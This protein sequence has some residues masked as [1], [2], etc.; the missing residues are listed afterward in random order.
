VQRYGFGSRPGVRNKPAT[1][2]N[3]WEVCMELKAGLHGQYFLAILL[4]NAISRRPYCRAQQYPGIEKFLLKLHC[5]EISQW[6]CQDKAIK[7]LG[8]KKTN[9]FP[10][11]CPTQLSV[12]WTTLLLSIVKIFLSL[13][14]FRSKSQ[15]SKIINL[16]FYGLEIAVDMHIKC[17]CFSNFWQQY[18][19]WW[20]HCSAILLQKIALLY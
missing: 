10:T 15:F 8:I 9:N 14:L 16:Q 4:S 3:A 18:C 17:K 7:N 19:H 1:K 11:F 6:S 12:C 13:F 5:W 20:L 2:E